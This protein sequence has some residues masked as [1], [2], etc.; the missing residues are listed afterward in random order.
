MIFENDSLCHW[1]QLWAK[2]CFIQAFST[3]F[4]T[5][6]GENK[7][8]LTGKNVLVQ[9]FDHSQQQLQLNNNFQL[10]FNL[11]KFASPLDVDGTKVFFL[12][13][14]NQLHCAIF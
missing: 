14:I 9:C 3:K 10:D 12:L 4:S 2:F 13:Q 1:E 8:T 11:S 7:P 5:S 6:S